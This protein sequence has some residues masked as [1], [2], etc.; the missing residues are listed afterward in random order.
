MHIGF[1]LNFRKTQRYLSILQKFYGQ[2]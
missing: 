2:D 1:S